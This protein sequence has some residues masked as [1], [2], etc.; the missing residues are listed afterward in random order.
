[1]LYKNLTK[2]IHMANGLLD[3]A[4]VDFLEAY[5]DAEVFVKFSDLAALPSAS[6]NTGSPKLFDEMEDFAVMC[7]R[8]G[9]GKD[10]RLVRSWVK[11]LRSGS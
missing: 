5:P 2:Y 4:D 1:V 3:V 10:A 6:D 9:N 7:D 8:A 11:Q